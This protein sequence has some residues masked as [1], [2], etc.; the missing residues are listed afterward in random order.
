MFGNI[1]VQTL[2]SPPRST[3]LTNAPRNQRQPTK[4]DPSTSTYVGV[5]GLL[6]ACAFVFVVAI[7][8][9]VG[10]SNYDWV[11]VVKN[12]SWFRSQYCS[13]RLNKSL[14][15]NSMGRYSDCSQYAVYFQQ[16]CRYQINS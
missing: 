6:F 15:Q 7:S 1:F 2:A 3:R 16:Q 13:I 5:F 8:N 12:V 14:V 10:I 9:C 11:V 4:R